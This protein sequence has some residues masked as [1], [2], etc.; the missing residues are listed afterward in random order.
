MHPYIANMKK[1]RPFKVNDNPDFHMLL[2]MTSLTNITGNMLRTRNVI[3][4]DPNFFL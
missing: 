4:C 2:G 3:Y 1:S